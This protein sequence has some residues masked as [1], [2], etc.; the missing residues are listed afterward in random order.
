MF[1]YIHIYIYI[2]IHVYIYIYISVSPEKTPKSQSRGSGRQP[3]SVP[4][5]VRPSAPRARGPWNRK[6]WNGPR[7]ESWE[8]CWMSAGK[9]EVLLKSMVSF[10]FKNG[11]VSDGCMIRDFLFFYYSDVGCFMILDV[12]ERQD[13]VLLVGNTYIWQRTS[14]WTTSKRG[15]LQSVGGQP[16]CA[17]TDDWVVARTQLFADSV[18]QVRHSHIVRTYK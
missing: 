17:F 5:R 18:E 9:G 16:G 1:I 12:P 15:V 3:W 7:R 2:R 11:W 4:P 6:W 13:W 10:V 14:D 8:A